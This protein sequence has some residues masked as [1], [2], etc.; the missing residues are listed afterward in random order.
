VPGLQRS[1]VFLADWTGSRVLLRG[2]RIAGG[3]KQY[4]QR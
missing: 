1:S 3:I 2:N 4:E